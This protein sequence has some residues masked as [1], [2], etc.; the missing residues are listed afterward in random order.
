M[1]VD[2]LSVPSERIKPSVIFRRFKLFKELSHDELVNWAKKIIRGMGL[3]VYRASGAFSKGF[4]PDIVT[5][6]DGTSSG[7]VIIDVVN[8]R[9]SVLR[10]IAGLLV[11]KAFV[12]ETTKN[13]VY[14]LICAVTPNFER[15]RLLYL[16]PFL[17]KF[18]EL[19]VVP[20][21]ELDVFLYN[22]RKEILERKGGGFEV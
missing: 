19:M 4:V 6:L 10:D 7:W 1:S 8:S 2:F 15:K 12:E 21:E 5:N 16:E 20:I 17:R 3:I 11:V 14:R 22:L 9:D 13:R 18:P